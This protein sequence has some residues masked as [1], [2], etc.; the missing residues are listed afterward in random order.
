MQTNIFLTK[1][2]REMRRGVPPM[3]SKQS[4]RVLN[5]ETS[6][7]PKKLKF[8]RFHIKTMLI[9]FFPRLS[10][11]SAQRIRTRRKTLNA[12]FYKGVMDCPLK[13]IHRVRPAAFCPR[14]FVLLPDNAPSHKATSVCQFLTPKMLKPFIAPRTPQIYLRRTIFCSPR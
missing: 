4:D 1:L 3:T 12:E 14:D 11:R 8:Q 6:P 5:G 9:I 2:L 7:R 10:R 13:R